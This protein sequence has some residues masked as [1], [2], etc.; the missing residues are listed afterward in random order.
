[1]KHAKKPVAY[2][3]FGSDNLYASHAESHPLANL[4]EVNGLLE[5]GGGND[6]ADCTKIVLS[7]L[8]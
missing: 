7:I 6:C 8:N 4:T 1:M 5:K 3:I 2:I